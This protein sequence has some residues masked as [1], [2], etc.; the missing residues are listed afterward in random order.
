MSPSHGFLHH[1]HSIHSFQPLARFV[2]Y[3]SATVY[4]SHRY[5]GNIV[6]LSPIQEEK[7]RGDNLPDNLPDWAS[8]RNWLGP[9][10]LADLKNPVDDSSLCNLCSFPLELFNDEAETMSSLNEFHLLTILSKRK[11]CLRSVITRFLCNF[12]V[13]SCSVVMTMFK[14]CAEPNS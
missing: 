4:L 10:G 12:R 11:C 1:A 8:P 9:E 14:K 6:I 3:L 2:I 5:F 13:S 7:E